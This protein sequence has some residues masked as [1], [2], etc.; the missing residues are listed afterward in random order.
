MPQDIEQVMKRT[1]RYYYEDGLVETAVGTLFIAIGLALLGWLMIQ[2][3]PVLGIVMVLVSTAAIFGGTLFVQRVIPALKARITHP[4][5]GSVTYRRDV[6]S[7]SRWLIV[8]AALLIAILSFNF[9]GYISQI[10][11]VI[12]LLLGIIF[13]VLGYRVRLRRFYLLGGV[14]V[15]VGM[16]TAVSFTNDITSAAS[17]FVGTGLIMAVIGLIVLKQY[18]QR[19]PI[20]EADYE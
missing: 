12:G 5:T 17:T 7:R 9:P 8:V 4:R 11:V 1:Q 2:T 6:P 18:V 16:V 15:I 20:A 3:S 13:S 10:S 14:A 19:H